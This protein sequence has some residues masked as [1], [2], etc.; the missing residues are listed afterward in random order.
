MYVPITSEVTLGTGTVL[1]EI[2]TGQLFE[3][4]ERLKHGAEVSGE[5]EWTITPVGDPE[6]Q[7]SPVILSRQELAQKF[8]A[9]DEA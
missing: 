5:D 3:V 8:F 6:A 2:S 9:D 4:G 7:R 1:R